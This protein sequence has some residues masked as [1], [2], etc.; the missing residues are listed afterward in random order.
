MTIVLTEKPSVARDFAQALDCSFKNGFFVSPEYIVVNAV[1][2]LLEL[3]LPDQYN[4]EWK[5]WTL[6]SLPIVPDEFEYFPIKRTEKQLFLIRKTIRESGYDKLIIATDAGREGELIAR[7]ILDYCNVDDYSNVF[8]FWS[9]EALTPEVIKVGLT[10]LKPASDYN[11]FYDVGKVRQVADW[12]VGINLSRLLSLKLQSVYSVGRVQTAVLGIIV[13]RYFEIK[14]FVSKDYFQLEGVFSNHGMSFKSTYQSDGQKDFDSKN[15]LIEIKNRISDGQG[16][17][18]IVEKVESK[19]MTRKPPL[20]YNL[21]ALQQV[22]NR[23]Y[24]YTAKVTL[25]IVQR[26]YEKYKCVSYPRTPSRVL[27]ESNV[28]FVTDLLEALRKVYPDIISDSCK[29]NPKNKRVFNDSKLE[30]HHALLPLSPIP[31]DVS[32]DDKKIYNLILVSFAVAFATDYVFYSMSV[33]INLKDECFIATGRKIVKPGWW[34]IAHIED[35]VN[36][37]DKDR[38]DGSEQTLQVLPEF[39]EGDVLTLDKLKV[40]SKKTKAKPRFT[41]ASILA[42]MERPEKHSSLDGDELDYHFEK[43]MGLGT[44]ATRATI[45]ETLIK[46]EY[47]TRDSKKLI[48]TEKG[49]HFMSLISKFPSLKKITDVSETARWEIELRRSPRI[50]YDGTVKEICNIVDDVKKVTVPPS[51]F[52]TSQGNQKIIQS[53]PLCK[54][55]SVYEGGKNYYCSNYRDGCGF[56]LWK[57][58]FGVTLGQRDI[59]TLLSGSKTRDLSLKRKDGSNFKA[60]LLLDEEGKLVFAP[61]KF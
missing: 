14:D 26:L 59:R 27:G 61:R 58:A 16:S 42:A 17:E 24:G 41:D 43:D 28:S 36:D 46:R 37:E 22:A 11:E 49:L 29:V 51:S 15:M 55:G 31:D 32:E 21:S 6:D 54:K 45:L 3:A 60:S 1:G 23:K 9:S 19:R 50:F 35:K 30:D 20:L 52:S 38:D 39:K 56:R 5:S 47:A 34:K 2:H 7:L 40:L 25:E 33:S 10:K 12:V 44:Q 48:P 4:P 18:G 8:R 53:C 13:K 57:K